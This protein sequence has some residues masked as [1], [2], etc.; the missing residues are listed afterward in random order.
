M[1][2]NLMIEILIRLWY[3]VFTLWDI[4][5]RM[6]IYLFSTPLEARDE[7]LDEIY[8]LRRCIEHVRFYGGARI[9]R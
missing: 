5:P 7:D 3:V 1:D 6:A 9:R 8:P 2:S 4:W